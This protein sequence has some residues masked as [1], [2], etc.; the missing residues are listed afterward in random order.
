MG[1]R[2]GCV[3]LIPMRYCGSA[4]RGAWGNR[5]SSAGLT[6]QPQ[7]YILALQVERCFGVGC[8]TALRNCGTASASG[9]A[10]QWLLSPQFNGAPAAASRNTFAERLR[11][12]FLHCPTPKQAGARIAWMAARKAAMVQAGRQWRHTHWIPW[13]PLHSLMT[14]RGCL[15]G[16][17]ISQWRPNPRGGQ[18]IGQLLKLGALARSCRRIEG[19]RFSI[20][21]RIPASITVEHH[22]PWR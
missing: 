11:W 13:S 17:H 3:R 4:P 16:G 1:H 12:R 8:E 21:A 5:G 10:R 22:P 9:F 19:M 20:L 7:S 18:M 14:A 15:A 6:P 2:R